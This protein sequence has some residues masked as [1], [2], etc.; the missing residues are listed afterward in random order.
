MKQNSPV[1]VSFFV[2]LLCFSFLLM[3]WLF[4]PFI[5]SIVIALIVTS[6]SNP[7]YKYLKNKIGKKKA[8]LLTC[9]LLLFFLLIPI[10]FFISALSKEAYE[11]YVWLKSAMWGDKIKLF[12]SESNLINKVNSLLSNFDIKLTPEGIINSITSSGKTISLFFF[13]QARGIATNVFGLV[14]HFCL[15]L[16]IVY[17]LLID[18]K[19]LFNFV[20]ALSPLPDSQDTQLIEKFKNISG[21][22]LIGN[23]L[24]G[25]IQGFLGGIAFA[26]FGF[27][28]PIVW[29]VIMA[30]VAFLPIV[31]IGIVLIP[32]I[33]ILLIMQKYGLAIFFSFFYIIL[34]GGIEYIFK[35]KLVG[36][37]VKI[38]PL[39][40]LL[41]ILGGLKL[42][43]VLGILYG[44]L[45]GTF[46]LTL[47]D[48]YHKKYRIN[49]IT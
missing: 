9:L 34:S 40:L 4:K 22:I 16:F 3:L 32:T 33:L 39:T 27:K 43:G 12:L 38:H 1:I 30:I 26:V 18:S 47:I 19:K 36:D 42:F 5:A 20:L 23:G 8:S 24:G 17:F 45:I 29:G 11:L 28:S 10:T 7:L 48:I 46:F 49:L 21:T 6:A 31:G 35:P 2:F 37:R 44:P 25:I 41:T 15:M 13:K 14:G